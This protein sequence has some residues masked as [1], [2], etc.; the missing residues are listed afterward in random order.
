MPIGLRH[1]EKTKKMI[2][3]AAIRTMKQPNAGFK[4]KVSCILC[5]QV[6]SPANLGKHYDRC[7]ETRGR[8]LDGKELSVFELKQMKQRLRKTCWTVDYYINS[9]NKQSGKCAIC[10]NPSTNKKLYADHCHKKDL[11]RAL[12]CITCNMA[13]GG[14]KDDIRLLNKAIE[15]LKIDKFPHYKD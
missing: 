15:Y 9:H 2:S 14:F 11:P 1:T 10:G 7:L 5:G 8:F 12:L 6:M 4:Q 13:L 3:D